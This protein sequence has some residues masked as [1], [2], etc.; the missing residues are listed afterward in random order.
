MGHG[1]GKMPRLVL[2]DVAGDH[3]KG[4]R[5]HRIW[6]SKP[7]QSYKHGRCPI[8]RLAARLAAGKDAD[9]SNGSEALPKPRLAVALSH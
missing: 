9:A 4:G 8:S 2:Q 3:S 7:R 1:A 6:K 5:W